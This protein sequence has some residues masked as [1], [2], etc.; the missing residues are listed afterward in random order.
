MR[1]LPSRIVLA[2]ALTTVA[3]VLPAGPAFAFFSDVPAGHWAHDAIDHVA[4]DNTWMQDYGTDEFHPNEL[5]SRNFLART[6]V[7][8]FAPDEPIDPE[9]TFADLSEDDEFF[10]F[11]NVA[12][13]LDWMTKVG[14]TWSG[15]NSVK[16]SKFDKALILAVGGLD[17]AIAGLEN[18]HRKDGGVYDLETRF[19]YVQL[20]RWFGLRYD[21]DDE[22]QDLQKNATMPRDEVAH[23][24]SQAVLLSS[25]Q[26]DDANA[27]F[28][29]VLLPGKL[30][31]TKLG[32]TQYGLDQVGYPYI[33]AGEWHK[34]N[35]PGYC[36]GTQ[37]QGGFDCSGF[38]WWVLKKDEGGYDAAQFRDYTGY[39][40][41]QRTSSSMAQAAP[42][43]ITFDDL[44]VGNPMFFASNGG[45]GWE[46]VD[47]V[48]IYLGENWMIHSTGGGPQL[49]WVGDGWYHDN[50]VWG[51]QLTVGASPRLPGF[52]A[53]RAGEPAVAP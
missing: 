32:L 9:I 38:V 31:D 34:K 33:Y 47:H 13:K 2:V 10:P 7:T 35:P 43:H 12:V 36:C 26:I 28:A 20:A 19:A 53:A 51:R 18:I 15:D 14:D 45:N 25:Y 21:H 11:A 30:N 23:A 48:G 44:K 37:P 8:V 24:L 17:V 6:L 5:E 27:T 50:Y 49:E 1:P 41:A 22:D 4:W 16:G 46:D 29:D 42:V 39:A 52:R 3:V 40:I